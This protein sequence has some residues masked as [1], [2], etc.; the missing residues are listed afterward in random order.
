MTTYI[1]LLRG[2]NV[3]GN[4]KVAMVDLRACAAP[5]GLRDAQTVL[6]SGNLVFRSDMRSAASIETVLEA[7]VTKRLGLEIE[8]H[9]RTVK[10]WQDAIARNPFTDAAKADPSQLLVSF[11]K[12]APSSKSLAALEAAIVGRERVRASGR[13]AYLVYPDG[14][15]R[16]KLTPA[17]LD[18]HLGRGTA[19]NWNTV[20]RLAAL[21]AATSS[22]ASSPSSP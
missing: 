8:I 21:A 11:F 18:R 12:A 4:C 2:I 13:Q 7:Q 5:S 16:S 19:R 22:R 9:V 3:G 14:M 6:Q 17:M 15:G 20:L 1:A 10:E